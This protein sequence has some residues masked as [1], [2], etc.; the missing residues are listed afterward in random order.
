MKVYKNENDTMRIGAYEKNG[1]YYLVIEK[2]IRMLVATRNSKKSHVEYDYK[3]YEK[4]FNNAQQANN[5]F[6]A[7]KKNNPTLKKCK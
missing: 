2:E 7:I 4:E 3:H 5:Y 6:K 1:K